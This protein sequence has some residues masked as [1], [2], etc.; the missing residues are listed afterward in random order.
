MLATGLADGSVWLFAQAKSRPPITTTTT[1][2]S[3]SSSPVR[4]RTPNPNPSTAAHRASVTGSTI[5]AG[6]NHNTNTSPTPETAGEF[7]WDRSAAN[8]AKDDVNADEGA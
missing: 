1:P 5:F 2:A 3:S 6:F 4:L 7:V 8:D